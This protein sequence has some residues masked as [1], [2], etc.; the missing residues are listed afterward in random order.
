[1]AKY[2]QMKTKHKSCVALAPHLIKKKNSPL[3]FISVFPEIWSLNMPETTFE[4]VNMHKTLAK[5]GITW[6]KK[7]TFLNNYA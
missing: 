3:E 2:T 4:K 1:M 6:L 7:L 5:G